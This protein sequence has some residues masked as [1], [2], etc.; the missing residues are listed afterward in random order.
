[1]FDGSDTSLANVTNWAFSVKEYIDLFDFAAYKQTRIAAAFLEKDAKTWY[2]NN[3][4]T[5][6]PPALDEFLRAFRD[7]SLSPTAT[8]I[9]SIAYETSN[10]GMTQLVNTPRT[11]RCLSFNWGHLIPVLPFLRSRITSVASMTKFAER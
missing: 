9:S 8:T 1:M 4:A 10:R 3:Y 5:V 11:S 6:D 7:S 2:C